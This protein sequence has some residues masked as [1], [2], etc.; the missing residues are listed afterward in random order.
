MEIKKNVTG[1]ISMSII[2]LCL[3]AALMILIEGVLQ[4]TNTQVD[5]PLEL[6]TA[7]IFPPITAPEGVQATSTPAIK[8]PDKPITIPT[9]DPNFGADG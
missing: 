4:V 7:I 1:K 2:L 8:T 9:L 3:I 5:Q 6:S